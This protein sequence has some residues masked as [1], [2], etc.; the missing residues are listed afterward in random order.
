MI[1]LLNEREVSFK[2]TLSKVSVIIA[3]VQF[4][5]VSR[6]LKQM[7]SYRIIFLTPKKRK[8]SV[9]NN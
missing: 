2:S 7:Y 1:F 3:P 6:S 4:Q 9:I 8:K 5:L